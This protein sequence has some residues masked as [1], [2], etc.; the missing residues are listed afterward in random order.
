[1]NYE[2]DLAF[3]NQEVL[4]QARY[5]LTTQLTTWR[6]CLLHVAGNSPSPQSS[7]WPANNIAHANSA[8]YSKLC[9]AVPRTYIA[10]YHKPTR[11]CLLAQ[12]KRLPYTQELL[13]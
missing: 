8:Q 12:V 9:P 7:L 4:Y 13:D 10:V 11:L 1:M 5:N 6:K 3:W 2:Y